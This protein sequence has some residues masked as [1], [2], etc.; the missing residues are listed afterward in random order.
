MLEGM[1]LRSKGFKTLNRLF[2]KPNSRT[3]SG[4]GGAAGNTHYAS[5]GYATPTSTSFSKSG[6]SGEN[7]WRSRLRSKLQYGSTVGSIRSQSPTSSE[8]AP[9][10]VLDGVSASTLENMLQQPHQNDEGETP[11]S[12]LR[13]MLKDETPARG[14]EKALHWLALMVRSGVQIPTNVFL[15]CCEGLV[16]LSQLSSPTPLGGQDA[17][18]PSAKDRLGASAQATTKGATAPALSP[19]ENSAVLEQPMMFLKTCWESIATTVHRMSE[20]DAGQILDGIMTSNQAMIMKV[21]NERSLTID[22]EGLEW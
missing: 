7:E 16:S 13:M 1:D 6:A 10:S 11:L 9:D 12:T 17:S 20:A 4:L 22:A 3:G 18:V 5:S 14:V 19:W 15:E 2:L 21:M 8:R